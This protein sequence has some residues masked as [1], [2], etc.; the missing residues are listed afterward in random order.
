MAPSPVRQRVQKRRDALRAAGMRPVQI[1]VPDTRRPCFE[2]E[3]RR[4]SLIVAQADAGDRDLAG[5]LDA[6]LADLDE[7][8]GGEDDA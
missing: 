6:A 1:W 3:C 4:Q 5:F 7:A 8:L 2:D